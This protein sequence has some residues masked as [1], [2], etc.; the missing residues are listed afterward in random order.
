MCVAMT[1]DHHGRYLCFDPRDPAQRIQDRAT[2]KRSDN[3]ILIASSILFATHGDEFPIDWDRVSALATFCEAAAQAT[4]DDTNALL[5]A[6]LANA[7]RTSRKHRR[8][9]TAP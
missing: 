4:L 9:T 5:H 1:Q 7:P 6:T 3:A 8:S 2:W